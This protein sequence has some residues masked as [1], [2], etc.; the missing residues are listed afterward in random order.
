MDAFWTVEE[1]AFRKAVRDRLRRNGGATSLPLP[2]TWPERVAVVEEAARHEPLFGLGL[3]REA[4]ART[5]PDAIAAAILDR[6]W[7]AGAAAHV[8]E[9]GVSAARE[10][11]DFAS[12]LMGCREV[13]DRLGGLASAVDLLRLGTCRLCRLVERGERDRAGSESAR[14]LEAARAL[15]G[16]ARAVALSL[17]GP[18]WL[19]ANW[20]EDGPTS[21]DE[22]TMP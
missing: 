10:R 15:G 12:S 3:A 17:L 6:A 19:Q 16:D 22:R 5:D 20:P 8:L 9:A 14:L 1:R 13:Q 7:L 11:G 18:A 4:R 2:R 21:N